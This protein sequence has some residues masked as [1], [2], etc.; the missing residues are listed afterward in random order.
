MKTIL[1]NAINDP[2]FWIFIGGYLYASVIQSLPDPTLN[3]A[4]W[5][6]FLYKFLHALG[7]NWQQYRN[8]SIVQYIQSEQKIEKDDNKK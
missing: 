4:G 7:A 1:I 2:Y 8:A 5:Y 6:V 3:A